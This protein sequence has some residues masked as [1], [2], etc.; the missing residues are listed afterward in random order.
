MFKKVRTKLTLINI[1]V[2]G[3]IILLFFSGIYILMRHNTQLQSE[4]QLFS[5]TTAIAMQDQR[6]NPAP[7]IR[8][9]NNFFFVK[10]G[11]NGIIERTKNIPV[12]DEELDTLLSGVLYTKE[13]TGIIE[14]PSER[15]RYCINISPGMRIVTVAFMSTQPEEEVFARLRMILIFSG[16]AGLLVV[17]VSSLFMAGRALIPIKNS[18]E[19]QKNF[20][21]DASH[22]LRSPLAVI[23]TSI[24][25]VMG[26]KN[27]TVDSQMKWLENIRAEN[28]RMTKLVNDLLT[29]A[30]AD[31]DQKLLEKTYFPLHNAINSAVTALEPVAAKKGVSLTLKQSSEIE[32]YGDE[33]KLKQLAVI[34]IDNAIKYTPSGGTAE[35]VL[36]KCDNHAELYVSDTGEGIESEHIEKIF[37]RFY[38]VDKA[39][40]RENG[41]TGLGLS[42]AD[43]I[44]K[45][46]KGSISVSSTPSKGTTFKVRLPL[47]VRRS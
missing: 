12:T 46:H 2:V 19:R 36:K 38:R 31:S 11:Q 15:F 30:R 35:V 42:I 20:V 9:N 14:L 7:P 32:I 10:Y 37:E 41:G 18:W 47:S 1:A 5:Y 21:A 13:N 44:V 27:E 26:N 25:L 24:E 28:E 34:L 4:Q 8:Q 39:R 16:L 43:W 6:P 3:I 22:E 17:Y 29:L 23:Q 40:S 45:E 33:G